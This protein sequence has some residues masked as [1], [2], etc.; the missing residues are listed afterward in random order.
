[1]NRRFPAGAALACGVLLVSS[2]VVSAAPGFWQAATQ[3]DFL[4]GDVDQLS[5]DEHGRLTLGPSVTRIHDAAAPFVW[6]ALPMPDGS[7]YLGTGNDGKVLRVDRSGA[8]SVFFDSGEMEVHA[9]APAPGGGVFVGTSPDGR[10]YRV[11]AKGQSTTFFDPEDKYI[12]ALA[13]DR[14]GNL[15]AAT[16]DKGVVYRITPDGKGAKFFSTKAMHAVSLALDANNQLL[17][18]TGSPGRVFRVDP[19]GK[20]FLLL[21]TPYSEVHALQ[22]DPKGVIYAAAQSSKPSTGGDS[23]PDVITAPPAPS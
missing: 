16:G 22:L 12:W 9:L 11:D 18:G 1:M 7:T 10:I 6:S 8:G 14:Q 13:V 5:I 3:A 20:G 21:D 4:R 2:L 19:A 15:F 23:T 17:V